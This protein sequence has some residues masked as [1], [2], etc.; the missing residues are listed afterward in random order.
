MTAI[1]LQN[2]KTQMK[3][4]LDTANTT[5]ASTDLSGSMS[6][7]IQKVL[8]LNPAKIPPQASFYPF[9]TVFVEGKE[10]P[11][12]DMAVS[13]GRAKRL[14]KVNISVVGAVF[15]SAITSDLDDPTELDINYLM[16]NVEQILRDDTTLNGACKWH[17]PQSVDYYDIFN[18][19][20]PFLKAGELKMQATIL[21]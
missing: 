15:H 10:L 17:L 14:A 1:N 8:T 4:I 12:T 2:L 3:T 18:E 5:T 11:E 13:L 20:E 7:R 16:E 6:A 9:V 21:Y 19:E